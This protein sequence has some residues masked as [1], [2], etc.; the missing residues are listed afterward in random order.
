MQNYLKLAQ[1]E[2]YDDYL[3]RLFRNKETYKLKCYEIANLINEQ[4]GYDYTESK[5]RKEW[6]IF[7]R[8]MEYV[9][10]DI[11]DDIGL[12]ILSLSDF[13][14]PFQ[15][16]IETFAQYAGKI[17]VLQLNGDI[18]DM[19]SISKFPKAY[20]ISPME[21]IISGRQYMIDLISFLKPKKVVVNYGNHDIRFQNYL[22]KKLD[23][24]LLELM[25]KSPLTLIFDK[26]FTHY[27]KRT[28]IES[29]YKPIKSIFNNIEIEYVDSWYCQIGKTVFCHPL[30]FSSGIMKTAE[31]AMLW[32]RNEGFIFDCLVMAHT[33]R[34]GEYVIG[35]S[36]LFEQGCCCDV[37]KNF[38]S[39]GRLTN[40]QK[41]GFIYVVQ[42]KN[43]E[44]LRDKT[45][46]ITL[47]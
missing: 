6:R 26:E 24:D 47:N 35:N 46:L 11:Q 9:T 43:G 18:V 45:K 20:R 34:I 4:F 15:L 13:H 42:D 17:D 1:G 16:P 2:T 12:R 25:P 40:S 27:N 38:Y 44:L 7:K 30:A 23:T 14:I 28:G 22:A 21:E 19:Q 32:F 41:E 33:H 31:K 36:C 37:D 29:T 5:Y 39:D 10:K 8:G 3:V